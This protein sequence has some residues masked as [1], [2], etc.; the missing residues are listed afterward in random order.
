METLLVRR[1]LEFLKRTNVYYKDI[2]INDDWI[3]E[4]CRQ[5]DGEKEDVES[6]VEDEG[7]KVE[8]VVGQGQVSGQEESQV[9]EKAVVVDVGEESADIT[10]DV[11][12]V[13]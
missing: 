2:E 4:F 13:T 6:D 11:T 8:Q 5:E 1:A 3:N 12:N 7:V 10:Q 9:V